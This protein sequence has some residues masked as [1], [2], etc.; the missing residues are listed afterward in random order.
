[1]IDYLIVVPNPAADDAGEIDRI[2]EQ[3]WDLPPEE[4]AARLEPHQKDGTLT[5]YQFTSWNVQGSR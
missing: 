2:M 5:A 1:M 3:T 4:I